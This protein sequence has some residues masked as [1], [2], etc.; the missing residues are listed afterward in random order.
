MG[1]KGKKRHFSYKSSPSG[2]DR[3]LRRLFLY[4]QGNVPVGN[5]LSCGISPFYL[6]VNG[7][8]KGT[9]T[10]K[11]GA[12]QPFQTANVS[13]GN[14]SGEEV[15]VRVVVDEPTTSQYVFQF[16]YIIETFRP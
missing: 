5:E 8:Q 14:T 4:D 7:V 2:R 12:Q 10:T 15:T 13:L 9:V 16:G 1:W 6:Y 3:L 11:T